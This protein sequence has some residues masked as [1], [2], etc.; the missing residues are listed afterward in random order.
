MK[1]P[2]AAGYHCECCRSLAAGS[3]AICDEAVHELQ[4]LY[5]ILNIMPKDMDDTNKNLLAQFSP[6][7]QVRLV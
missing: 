6:N 3:G 4:R 1:R 7:K 5:T 2:R